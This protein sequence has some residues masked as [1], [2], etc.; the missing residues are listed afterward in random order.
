MVFRQAKISKIAILGGG[1][2]GI[3]LAAR[4]LKVK[5]VHVT[6]FEND[7]IKSQSFRKN[8]FLVSEPGL[9]EVLKKGIA[10]MNLVI[11]D[12]EIKDG[13]NALFICIGSP[14]HQNADERDTNFKL[15]LNQYLSQMARD[16][17]IFLRSTVEIGTTDRLN[18]FIALSD[19]PDVSIHFA[20]E[21]TAEGVALSELSTL[22][23]ILGSPK[24]SSKSELALNFLSFL[25]FK[26]FQTENAKTSELA[27]LVCNTWRDVTFGFAN[28]L[29]LMAEL[30][31]VEAKKV[32]EASNY[33]YSRSSIPVPGP[34]GGP[35]LS[36][37]TSILFNGLPPSILDNFSVM[38][39]ARRIN[40]HVE[41]RLLDQII[42]MQENSSKPLRIII[43]GAAFKGNPVTNDVRNGVALNLFEGLIR[44]EARVILNI[45]D[46]VVTEND[47][48]ELRSL[49]IEKLVD[50]NPEI[51]II[52]NNAKFDQNKE[53]VEFMEKLESDVSV[54]DMWGISEELSNNQAMFRQLGR[55]WL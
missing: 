3:T 4:L 40:E 47:L 53:F 22:P 34:V 44:S 7:E 31:G 13:F 8:D 9:S 30:T 37:D 14:K 48:G 27:K 33:K 43:I 28:E 49:R 15:I 32:I 19:R 25:E 50:V 36:K 20:P 51:V 24:N 26:V 12:G 35:C 2:V 45:W 21:R 29:A 46:P 41:E 18:D 42:D 6:V 38:R 54:F 16:G 55:S 1:F 23:Q 17:I 39:S 5:N 52:A 11:N 10:R